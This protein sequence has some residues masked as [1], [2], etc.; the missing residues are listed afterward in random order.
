MCK[1]HHVSGY[2]FNSSHTPCVILNFNFFHTDTTSGKAV[3]THISK[4][5]MFPLLLFHLNPLSDIQTKLKD[6]SSNQLNEFLF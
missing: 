5:S 6:L 4:I 1:S 2:D 3:A